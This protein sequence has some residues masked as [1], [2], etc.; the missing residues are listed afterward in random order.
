MTLSSAAASGDPIAA[1]SAVSLNHVDDREPGH[2]RKRGTSFQYVAA[3]GRLVRDA[4]TLSRLRALAI[5]PT[6]TEVWSSPDPDDH[7]L[8]ATGKPSYV[9]PR[10]LADFMKR[11]A[12]V[13]RDLAETRKRRR[14]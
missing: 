12:A 7:H 9:D 11:H 2:R 4:A 3:S 6:W 8:Q 13:A 10:V 14:A 5:P 1:A